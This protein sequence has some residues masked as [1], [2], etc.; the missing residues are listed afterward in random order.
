M[1]A[2]YSATLERTT[3]CGESFRGKLNTNRFYSV[4]PNI[5]LSIEQLKEITHVT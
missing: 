5:F 3:N 4:N 1:Y 2:D